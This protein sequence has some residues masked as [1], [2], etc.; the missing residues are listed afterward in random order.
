MLPYTGHTAIVTVEI[1]G[2]LENGEWIEGSKQ[3]LAIKGRYI[4]GNNGSQVVKN[5]DGDEV[6]Y[7]G[8]FMTS[9]PENKDAVRLLVAS[10]GVEAPIINWYPY[11]SHTVIY[12]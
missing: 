8:R 10:K 7:K 11:D 3:E 5:K 12:I 2:H 6:I 9:T 4:P 1:G